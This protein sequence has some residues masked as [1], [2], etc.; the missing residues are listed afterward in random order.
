MKVFYTL[1]GIVLA[2]LLIITLYIRSESTSFCGIAETKEIVIN[3]ETAVEI[4]KIRIMPGQTV[5]CGDTLVELRDPQ[6]LMKINDISHELDE[7]T[8][9]KKAHVNLS[10]SELLQ[11]KSE[12]SARINSLRAQIQE[13]EAQYQ[14]NRKLVSELRSIK[15]ENAATT[16]G[17]DSAN[18]IAIKIQRFKA[19]LNL[20]LDSSHIMIGRLQDE[21]LYAGNPL[22]ERVKGLQSELQ[23]L[24]E[25]K[26]K[27]FKIAQ[28]DGVIGTVNFKEGETVSPFAAIATLHAA[29]PSYVEG[30]IHENV[31]SLV[32]I[33]KEV[34]VTSFSDRRNAV[35][36]KVI[37]VGSRIVEYPVRLRRLPDLQMWGREVTI[38]IPEHNRF[39]LGEKVRIEL[40]AI[41]KSRGSVENGARL[42]SGI[43][44]ARVLP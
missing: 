4:A 21:L 29:S 3:A 20:A 1:C 15:K 43:M 9:Q 27:L 37:G 10:K 17:T 24:N 32:S 22:A 8:S 11:L 7:L 5:K 23:M 25:T 36:G 40:S 12:Q 26:N 44:L 35:R 14:I 19:D 42:S 16:P 6:L 39:L 28:I 33:G 13:L 34:T 38:R 41:A 18:P 2:A 30:Y 31:Y